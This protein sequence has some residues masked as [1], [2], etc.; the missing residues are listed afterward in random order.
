MKIIIKILNPIEKILF[1]LSGLIKKGLQVLGIYLEMYNDR[2]SPIPPIAFLNR[3]FD[4]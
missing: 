4:G 2:M 1:F 3:N